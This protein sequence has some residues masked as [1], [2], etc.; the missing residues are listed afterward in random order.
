M[1]LLNSR[2][3]VLSLKTLEEHRNNALVKANWHPD[4]YPTKEIISRVLDNLSVLHALCK[5]Y[6]WQASVDKIDMT[7][8]YLDNLPEGNCDWSSLESDL[9]NIADMVVTD[10]GRA[11]FAVVRGAFNSYVENDS[12]I[13]DGFVTDFPKAAGDVKEAGN[14]IAVDC[15]TAAVFHLMR[16]VEWGLRA[17]SLDL[18]LLET[19]YRDKLV[20]IEYSQWEQILN[21]LHPKIEE[22]VESLPRG[23][24]KQDAQEFYLALWFDIKGFRDAF[25]NHV[26]HT[27]KTFSQ[28]DA[29][30]ILDHVRRFFV[31]LKTRIS[32]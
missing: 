30:A 11:K 24:A 27:R 17:L 7:Y 22:R 8:G 1:E 14:C 29:D 13:Y 2:N 10:C 15:G 12:L 5:D 16:G 31:L 18:G 32:E 3:L 23:P 9:R 25:R 20:P 19:R 21:Q 28:K 26:S 6:C 4:S